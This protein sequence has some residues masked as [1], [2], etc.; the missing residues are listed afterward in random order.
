[1]ASAVDTDDRRLR[2]LEREVASNPGDP[3]AWARLSQ[4]YQ[5]R[6]RPL[7]AV[8]T[9][10]CGVRLHP[11]AAE[12]RSR[13]RELGCADGPWSCDRGGPANTQTSLFAGPDVGV[14]R[15][16]GQQPRVASNRTLVEVQLVE[17]GDSVGPLDVGLQP[18]VPWRVI[19]SRLP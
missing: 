15:S 17:V 11:L 3:L 6:G 1:M 2:R 9:A 5:R 19:T 16:L 7:D 14:Q 12:L 4:D 13:L 18:H 10:A 8:E